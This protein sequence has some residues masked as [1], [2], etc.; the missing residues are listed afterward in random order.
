M[1]DNWIA[2]EIVHIATLEPGANMMGTAVNG[3]DFEVPSSE[4]DPPPS[5]SKQQSGSESLLD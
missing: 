3:V 5:A 4:N 2:Q 1:E